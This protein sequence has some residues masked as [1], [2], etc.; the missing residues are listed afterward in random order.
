MRFKPILT[1]L[2]VFLI[3]FGTGSC[4]K[5][6]ECVKGN[7]DF[8]QETRTLGAFN[9]VQLTGDAS[10]YFSQ[11]SESRADIFAESNIV[12]L[13]TT[14]VNDQKMLSIG[15]KSDAC[16]NTTHYP[17]VTLVSPDC[18]EFTLE[19]SGNFSTSEFNGD[20]YK[21][22]NTASGNVNT[23]LNTNRLVIDSRGSGNANFAGASVLCDISLA[24]SGNVYASN[25]ASDTCLVV[26]DGSGNIT[27]RVSSLLDVTIKGSGN[28]YYTGNPDINSNITGSGELI[29]QGK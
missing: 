26:S 27:V 5:S 2:P 17:E 19:G 7:N 4:K 9:S 3:L 28:V 6:P 14:T 11:G 24:G 1:A 12:P 8:I 15:V 25:L 20:Y 22:T 23:V 29:Q 10:L 18:Y 13:I 21:I 16:Y